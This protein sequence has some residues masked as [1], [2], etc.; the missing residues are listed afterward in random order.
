VAS[1][2]DGGA[3]RYSGAR[4]LDRKIVEPVG[5]LFLDT[6]QVEPDEVVGRRFAVGTTLW[7]EGGIDVIEEPIVDTDLSTH[8]TA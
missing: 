6:E 3:A 7:S 8:W 1:S 2:G 5:D 4:R